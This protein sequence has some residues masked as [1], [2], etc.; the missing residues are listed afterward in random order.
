MKATKKT[1]G[2]RTPAAGKTKAFGK[3]IVRCRDA[4]VHFGIYVKHSGREVTLKD[5][6]RLWYWKAASG[7][8]L[9]AVAQV[10]IASESKIANKVGAIILLDACEIIPCTA[11]AAASIES[12]PCAA[13]R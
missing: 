9:S 6:R 3:V 12:A 2:K 1:G 5:S 11:A 8:S 7:I 4:G 13:A 10:G